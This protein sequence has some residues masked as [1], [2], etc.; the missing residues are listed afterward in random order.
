M[1]FCSSCGARLPHEPPV[2]CPACRRSHWQNPK[3]CAGALVVH[4]SRLLLVRRAHDPWRGLWDIPGGFC[5]IGEHPIE[6]AVREVREETGLAIAVTGFLGIWNDEYGRAA[7]G[8]PPEATLNV[9]Y[10][11]VTL[12][13]VAAV[14]DPAEVAEVGWF[15][16][17]D[18]LPTELAFPTHSRAALD[19][20]LE[21]ERA[22]RSS[23]PLPDHPRR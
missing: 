10:H 23:T 19:A 12:G 5:A 4:A 13:G 1:T 17:E 14:N 9:Y 15:T 21:A 11:A 20:W 16:P 3:P 7:Q 2:R 18:G 6:T 22:G 8:E